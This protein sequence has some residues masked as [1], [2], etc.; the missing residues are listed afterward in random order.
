MKKVMKNLLQR[1]PRAKGKHQSVKHVKIHHLF[2]PVTKHPKFNTRRPIIPRPF[3]GNYQCPYCISRIFADRQFYSEHEEEEEEKEETA[4]QKT[5][6]QKAIEEFLDETEE[7][8]MHWAGP[9]E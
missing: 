6:R 7:V 8:G 3:K 1:H 9:A 5:A 4:S 2:P